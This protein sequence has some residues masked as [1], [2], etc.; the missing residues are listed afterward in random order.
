[1]GG[2]GPYLR[3]TNKHPGTRDV[4]ILF[5]ENYKRERI[6]TILDRFLENGFFISAKNDFQLCRAYKLGKQTYIYNVDLLHPTEGKINKVDFIEILDL[7]VTVDGIRVKPII[8]VNIQYGD[9]IY[10]KNLYE[11]IEF[12]GQIFNVLDAAGIIVSKINSCHNKRRQRDIFDIYLSLSEKNTTEK[13]KFLTGINPT[14]DENFNDYSQKLKSSWVFYESCLREFGVNDKKSTG[15]SS[16]GT[17]DLSCPSCSQ[18]IKTSR[19][20]VLSL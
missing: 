11:K 7:D 14:L 4:D 13:I 15:N 17:I 12:N 9:V 10:S 3:H 6:V 18:K 2:W 19:T 20:A 8:T 5:P 16:H 1:M